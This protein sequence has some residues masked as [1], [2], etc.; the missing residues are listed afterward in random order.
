V[1]VLDEPTNDLDLETLELLE[2]VLGEW[3]G[4]L[5][6]V[7]HDRVFLDDIVTSTIVFEGD[8]RVDEYVGG[9][10]DWVRQRPQSAAA[11]PVRPRQARLETAERAPARAKRLSYNESRE[12]ATLPDQIDSLEAEHRGLNE[13]IASADFYKEAPEAIRDA[14]ARADRLAVEITAAYERWNELQSRLG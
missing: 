8:G 1:L 5:L 13:R 12:L 6:L 14:L 4:T 10:E 11:Q 9:Y 7:S 2:E 3:S